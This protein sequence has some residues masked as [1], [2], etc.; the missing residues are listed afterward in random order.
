LGLLNPWLY[1]AASTAKTADVA[2]DVVQGNND[3]FGT[4]CC[5]AQQG[6]DMA[7]GWG[8]VDFT[9]MARLQR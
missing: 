7:S 4:G 1:T 9:V 3:L 8:S 5:V 6:Y 2:I